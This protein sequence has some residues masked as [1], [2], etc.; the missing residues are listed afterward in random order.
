MILGI[1]FR[2]EVVGADKLFKIAAI[3]SYLVKF[4][5]KLVAGA[6]RIVQISVTDDYALTH[7]IKL[8]L[9]TEPRR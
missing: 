4:F 9:L 6:T 1:N 3:T 8:V 7:G 2:A 5:I